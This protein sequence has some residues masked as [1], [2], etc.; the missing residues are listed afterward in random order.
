MA[1][2]MMNELYFI[3]K[4]YSN[5]I[6]HDRLQ[7]LNYINE[8]LANLIEFYK[9]ESSE[10]VDSLNED[11]FK[12][13]DILIRDIKKLPV[14]ESE[15]MPKF[16]NDIM[17]IDET[18]Y[19][20]YMLKEQL[21]EFDSILN[22]LKEILPEE[23]ID[24]YEDRLYSSERMELLNL[25]IGLKDNDEDKEEV[26]KLMAMIDYYKPEEPKYLY[27]ILNTWN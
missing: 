20:S 7:E 24:E 18:N 19:F 14:P 22:E 17:V 12:W 6:Y 3:E 11:I 1:Y 10:K 16:S 26:Y 9:E 27:E 4:G 25:L 8:T 21:E 15:E 2:T 13:T 5:L 23:V